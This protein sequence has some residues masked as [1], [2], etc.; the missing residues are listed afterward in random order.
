MRDLPSPVV[1]LMFGLSVAL[2]V[3][4]VTWALE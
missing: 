3:A 2:V 4:C 1:V